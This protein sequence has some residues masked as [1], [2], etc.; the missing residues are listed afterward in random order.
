MTGERDAGSDDRRDAE[1]DK[2]S[3]DGNELLAVLNKLRSNLHA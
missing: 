3:A 1:A 2:R